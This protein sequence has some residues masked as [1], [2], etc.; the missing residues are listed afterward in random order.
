MWAMKYRVAEISGILPIFHRILDSCQNRNNFSEYKS[1]EAGQKN[2]QCIKN[3]SE[4]SSTSCSV[5][6]LGS[7]TIS[8]WSLIL[9]HKDQKSELLVEQ[10]PNHFKCSTCSIKQGIK[11]KVYLVHCTFQTAN[12]YLRLLGCVKL[13]V[14]HQ[15]YNQK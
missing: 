4:I 1:T 7:F 14:I 10:E 6:V 9:P 11:R 12:L 5:V 3:H 15:W 8:L 2:K 13:F